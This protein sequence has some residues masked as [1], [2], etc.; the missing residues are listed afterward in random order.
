MYARRDR[1]GESTLVRSYPNTIWRTLVHLYHLAAISSLPAA[2]RNGDLCSLHEADQRGDHTAY[3]LLLNT[4]HLLRFPF[5]V[6][7][8]YAS[9]TNSWTHTTPTTDVLL[10]QRVSRTTL[11]H[12]W[13]AYSQWKF[14][15]KSFKSVMRA[16]KFVVTSYSV[17]QCRF[18]TEELTR[19]LTHKPFG[20]I[21]VKVSTK[22][23]WLKPY[24]SY[25]AQYHR[26][27]H[28]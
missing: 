18:L 20:K 25:Y 16:D 15:N 5:L 1:A 17:V 4:S 26:L 12:L 19:T 7:N 6:G 22:Y 21:R 28:G 27:I 11:A 24:T 9:L 14:V 23:K 3:Y 8:A 2:G 10:K 13:L